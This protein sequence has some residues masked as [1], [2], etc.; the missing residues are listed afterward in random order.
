MT[1]KEDLEYVSESIGYLY[2]PSSHHTTTRIIP[3]AR[4]F[5]D[6]HK[7]RLSHGKPVLKRK[8]HELQQAKNM[9]LKTH[10]PYS[11]HPDL[12]RAYNV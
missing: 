7:N 9:I 2:A 10:I 6:N 12:R 5:S 1:L 4:L 8:I 3:A 11:K